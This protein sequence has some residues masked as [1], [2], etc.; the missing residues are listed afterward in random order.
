[1]QSGTKVER[2]EVKKC[3]VANEKMKKRLQDKSEIAFQT[4]LAEI[5]KEVL[6]MSESELDGM[7]AWLPRLSKYNELVWYFEECSIN[8]LGVWYPAG[9]LPEIWCIGSVRETAHCILNGPKEIAR[10]SKYGRD[11]R[12]VNNLPAIMKVATIILASRLFA[13]IVVPGGTWRPSPPCRQMKGDIDDGCLRAIAFA[14]K[15]YEKFNAYVG[16]TS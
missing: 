3:F 11:K 6:V 2:I 1:M 8:D 13:P 16:K 10:I 14:L 5:E 12:A 15:G 7:I 9:G 4:I